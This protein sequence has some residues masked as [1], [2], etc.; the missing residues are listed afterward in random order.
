MAPKTIKAA[1]VDALEDL[2][3]EDMKK[4]V[5]K[6]LDRRE[7]PRVKRNRVDGK[8]RLDVVDVMVATFTEEPA[9]K[10]ALD[11]LRDIC[12]QNVAERLREA[13][14][15][16]TSKPADSGQNQE[17][18]D[19]HF[20]DKH[21]RALIERISNIDPILDQL[22]GSVIQHGAYDRIRAQLTT[23]DKVRELFKCLRAGPEVKDRFY[24][25]LQEEE[26]YL[27]RDLQKQQ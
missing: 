2:S 24:T 4:F 15:G 14:A 3:T 22:L 12:C 19:E 26:G 7:E 27:I 18:K 9:L 10:L 21:R 20:V 11:I 25:V 6:L 17:S 8:D 1:L 16:L 23:Q 5:H 13:T